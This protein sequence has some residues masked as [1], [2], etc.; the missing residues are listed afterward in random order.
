MDLG[1]LRYTGDVRQL[2][3]G[4]SVVDALHPRPEGTRRD[5]SPEP[6]PEPDREQLQ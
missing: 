3:E 1:E 4:Q 5:K 2:C 6:G